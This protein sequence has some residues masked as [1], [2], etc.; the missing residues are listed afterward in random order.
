VDEEG[1]SG[2]NMRLLA[3]RLGTS[4]A[5]L[6]RHVTGKEE[7]MVHVVERLLGEVQMPGGPRHSGRGTWQDAMRRMAVQYR[8]VLARHP[9]MLPLV[10]AQLPIGPN[11][12]ALRERSIATLTGFGFSRGLAARAFTTI[13][14]YVVGSALA[15][16]GD[17]GPAEAAAIG[18]YYRTLD[19]E[20]FPHV[21]SSADEL[22][23][24]SPEDGF[25]AGLQIVLDGIDRARRRR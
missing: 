6:Y 7:L 4:T 20:V 11:A 17:P 13:L 22:T 25:L 12:L 14:Q 2:F 15:Q 5:T 19:P 3:D 18:D 1:D 24:V 21:V 16:R 8:G 9:N 23:A 10:V